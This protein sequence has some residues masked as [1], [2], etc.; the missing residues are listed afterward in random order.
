[1]GTKRTPIRRAGNRRT[2][3]EAIAIFREM[4]ALECDCPPAEAREADPYWEISRK[5]AGCERWWKLVDELADALGIRS[6]AEFPC[7]ED[8]DEVNPYPVEHANHKWWIRQRAENP[9]RME[10]WRALEKAARK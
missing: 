5:C 2:T 9:H 7:I 8:P 6:P 3:P 1:M 4:Q 10:L